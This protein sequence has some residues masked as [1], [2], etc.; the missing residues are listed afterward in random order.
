MAKLSNWSFIGKPGC[1]P[2]GFL[3]PHNW[4]SI[5]P[6]VEELKDGVPTLVQHR[7]PDLLLACAAAGNRY[8]V[9]IADVSICW[10]D[11]AAADSRKL[12]A[13]RPLQQL[14]IETLPEGSRV[15]VLP[16]IFT[17]RGAPPPNWT[18]IC[19]LMKFK[20]PADVMLRRI[21]T[22]V[23]TDLDLI[24]TT[25]SKQNYADSWHRH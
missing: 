19:A 4:Q 2:P 21:Q 11:I 25:W 8:C 3:L 10:N 22:S 17:S 9:I 23:L 16:I 5:L 24:M 6:R 20:L 18:E 7:L 13:Y 1:H 12:R 15:I 14:M